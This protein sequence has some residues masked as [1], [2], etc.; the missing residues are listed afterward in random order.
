MRA[1]A[2]ARFSQRGRTKNLLKKERKKKVLLKRRKQDSGL[3]CERA[4]GRVDVEYFARLE[5]AAACDLHELP[6]KDLADGL[7]RELYAASLEVG[8]ALER[9]HRAPLAPQPAWL[10]VRPWGWKP[11][12]TRTSLR[13]AAPPRA[14]SI[15]SVVFPLG[16]TRWTARWTARCIEAS[17][18]SVCSRSRVRTT[19]NPS[20]TR[21]EANA[22]SNEARGMT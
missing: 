22:A 19:A 15:K 8:E 11:T 13:V 6:P 20:T 12:Q 21:V 10:G 18:E 17:T 16:E 5:R 7:G 9:P 4:V 2:A 14:L 1:C 3:A